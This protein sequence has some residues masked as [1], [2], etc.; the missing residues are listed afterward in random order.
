MTSSPSPRAGGV[1]ASVPRRG[2]GGGVKGWRAS[3]SCC[4]SHAVKNERSASTRSRPLAT[5]ASDS[6]AA[7]ARP[8]ADRWPRRQAGRRWR[9]LPTPR[10][11]APGHRCRTRVAAR[12]R[13]GRARRTRST[14]GDRCS[15]SSGTKKAG[16]EKPSLTKAS[17]SARSIT[18]VAGIGGSYTEKTVTATRNC[19]AGQ[20]RQCL[21][22]G[23]WSRAHVPLAARRWRSPDGAPGRAPY[24]RSRRCGGYS[25]HRASRHAA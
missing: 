9:S 2:S 5:P 19:S 8:C 6:R 11:S 16:Q 12:Y 21:I 15:Q 23:P 24:S 25:R 1:R 22:A 18:S 17:L 7:R 10:A 14:C 20:V 3:R 4:G 13:R